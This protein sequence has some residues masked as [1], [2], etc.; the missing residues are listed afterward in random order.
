MIL[1]Y[2]IRGRFGEELTLDFIRKVGIAYSKIFNSNIAIGHDSRESSPI[3]AKCFSEGVRVNN[4]AIKL[5][6]VTNPMAYFYCWK[7][8]VYGAY[9]TA[10]HNPPEYNGVKFIEKD[11]TSVLEK[12]SEIV[13]LAEK[14][15]GVSESIYKELEDN[16]YDQYFTFIRKEFEDINCRIGVETFGGVGNLNVRILRELGAYVVN[17]HENF[18]PCFYGKRPEPKGDNLRELQEIVKRRNLDFG[19]AYDGDADRSVFVDN[20]GRVLNGSQMAMIFVDYLLEKRKGKI[21]IT[22]DCAIEI[23][24]LVLEK[25]GELIWWRVGHSYIEKKCVEEKAIFA[26]EQS[27]H[28]YFN[29]YYPFSDGL[30]ATLM[31]AK[32]LEDTE[33]KLSDLVDKHKINPIDKIYVNVNS[34]EVKEKIINALRS[35]FPEAKDVMDGLRINLSDEEW[36]LIRASQTMPEVNICAQ[37]KSEERLKN[38]VEEYKKLVL[39]LAKKFR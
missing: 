35:K 39:D 24:K 25:G 23:E 10:S 30:L 4:D 13:N 2:D 28:F 9:I 36:V 33:E 11:G 37:A 5:G 16:A 18:D 15:E 32:V 1:G 22:A 6:L 29:T 14:I 12:L 3:I 19:V 26:A 8:S 7:N 34:H 17:L 27:S 38:I 20:K 21:I 31:L